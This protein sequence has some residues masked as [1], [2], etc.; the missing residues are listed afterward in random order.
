MLFLFFESDYSEGNYALLSKSVRIFMSKI[1]LCGS[2]KKQHFSFLIYDTLEID[3]LIKSILFWK[4]FVYSFICHQAQLCSSNRLGAMLNWVKLCKNQ[5]CKTLYN[6]TFCWFFIFFYNSIWAH[7][8]ASASSANSLI[9]RSKHIF[10]KK[11]KD[12]THKYSIIITNRKNVA[13]FL[14]A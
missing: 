6:S 7:C 13:F 3:K 1:V 12:I 2:K 11:S 10:M 8:S 9:G 14:A 4:L 5:V